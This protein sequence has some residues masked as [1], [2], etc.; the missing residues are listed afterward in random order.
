MYKQNTKYY[1]TDAIYK[2][3]TVYNQVKKVMKPK[4]NERK[5]L[6]REIRDCSK[7]IKWDMSEVDWAECIHCLQ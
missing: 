6:E 2:Q 7:D 3:G 5:Y 1:Y 4:A